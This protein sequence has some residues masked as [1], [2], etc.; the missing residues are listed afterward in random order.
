MAPASCWV[1]GL[2]DGWAVGS[3]CWVDCLCMQRDTLWERWQCLCINSNIYIRHLYSHLMHDRGW[4]VWL[5]IALGLQGSDCFRMLGVL[6]FALPCPVFV[7]SS[8]PQVSS[9]LGKMFGIV[10]PL[11]C[12]L[13]VCTV[14]VCVCFCS[15][16]LVVFFSSMYLLP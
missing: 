14:C 2:L 7:M 10:L 4:Q 16:D 15:S 12:E 13:C 11:V 3:R 6:S 1:T 5:G 8:V 9:V